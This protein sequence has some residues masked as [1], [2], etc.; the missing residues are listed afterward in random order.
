MPTS[1]WPTRP[2]PARLTGSTIHIDAGLDR[3]W[4]SS[5]DLETI[6]ACRKQN[7]LL[8][9]VS[10]AFEPVAVND[11]NDVLRYGAAATSSSA[12]FPS[13]DRQRSISDGVL[14]LGGLGRSGRL[15]PW[16]SYAAGSVPCI[17]T[18]RDNDGI[19]LS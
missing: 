6:K 1:G 5:A 4:S 10:T 19:T 17:A 2:R 15:R 13:P 14:M 3:Q 9:G 7:G 12:G 11:P 18:K 8:L 16:M